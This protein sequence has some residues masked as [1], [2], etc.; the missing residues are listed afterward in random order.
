MDETTIHFAPLSMEVVEQVLACDELMYCAGAL[1][2]E[3]P[4][5]APLVT[6][7]D[8]GELCHLVSHSAI[9]QY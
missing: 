4:A 9:H 1:M 7:L 6:K 2:I 3:H 8:G 5:L